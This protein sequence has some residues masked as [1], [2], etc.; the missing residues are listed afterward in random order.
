MALR[1]SA[2]LGPSSAEV[3]A[4][5]MVPSASSMA[6]EGTPLFSALSR[7]ATVVRR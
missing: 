6:E 3:S 4:V 7:A 5:M 2:A 1:I